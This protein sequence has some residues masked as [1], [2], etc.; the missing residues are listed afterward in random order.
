MERRGLS[1]M[2]ALRREKSKSPSPAPTTTW[3]TN[4]KSFRRP[5]L[6]SLP[7]T[8]STR[9][10]SPIRVTLPPSLPPPPLS[11]STCP[12]LPVSFPSL[13]RESF[14][15]TQ[16]SRRKNATKARRRRESQATTW[17][18]SPSLLGVGQ[19]LGSWALDPIFPSCHALSTFYRVSELQLL[20]VECMS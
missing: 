15:R 17:L 6:S 18:S 11:S 2:V 12:L 10:L 7:P 3:T 16:A 1:H 19:L 9:D 8:G 20:R 14:A 13:L 5:Q 4:R